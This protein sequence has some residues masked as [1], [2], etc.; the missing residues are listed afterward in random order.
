MLTGSC[1]NIS[2]VNLF[3]LACRLPHYAVN[4]QEAV[5]PLSNKRRASIAVKKS[6]GQGKGQ[7]TVP[8][9][10]FPL[11]HNFCTCR[12]GGRSGMEPTQRWGKHLLSVVGPLLTWLNILVLCISNMVLMYQQHVSATYNIAVSATSATAILVLMYQQYQQQRSSTIEVMSSN[13]KAGTQSQYWKDIWYIETKV[14]WIQLL[15][16]VCRNN[17]NLLQSVYFLCYKVLSK[18]TASIW[19]KE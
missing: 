9:I 3:L 5:S 4:K 12:E 14:S 13:A 10:G 19:K 17:F 1:P 7:S 2:S 8:Y 16:Y 11:M 6:D 18:S 15:S